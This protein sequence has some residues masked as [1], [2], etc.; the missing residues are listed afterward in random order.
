LASENYDSH[1][2]ASP[3]CHFASDG[4]VELGYYSGCVQASDMTEMGEFLV[5]AW[6]NLVKKCDIIQYNARL[7]GGG[8]KGL[9]E[10]DVIGL[11]QRRKIAYLCEVT[12]HLHG[13][14]Y[15]NYPTTMKKLR[16]KFARDRKF[17]S[18]M[19]RGFHRKYMLWAPVVPEGKLTA[20]LGGLVKEGIELVINKAYADK[21]EELKREAG[22]REE[23]TGNPAFRLLQI[24]GHLRR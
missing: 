1:L 18:R 23:D 2:L 4:G 3:G 6:L 24:L 17:A 11:D 9:S 22:D 21:I 12:T 13:V 8:V 16:S 20:Q 5:G 19:L 10:V 15:E 14:L 7:P